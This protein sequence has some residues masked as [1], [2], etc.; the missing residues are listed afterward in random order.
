MYRLLLYNVDPYMH[1]HPYI[2][3]F[4][5]IVDKLILMFQT[6]VNELDC[7]PGQLYREPSILGGTEGRGIEIVVP[8]QVCISMFE[9]I[10]FYVHA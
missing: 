1:P 2:H 7:H 8:T 4:N 6:G 3:T 10:Y 9:H 5:D